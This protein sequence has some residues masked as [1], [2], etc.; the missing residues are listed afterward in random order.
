M[1]TRI[2]GSRGN[3]Q[4]FL[5]QF[6]TAVTRRSSHLND[7]SEILPGH[8][9]YTILSH[10]NLWIVSIEV[11]MVLQLEP[12]HRMALRVEICPTLLLL[13]TFMLYVLYA[14][15]SVYLCFLS[16]EVIP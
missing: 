3:V 4:S 10:S 11:G 2:T 5:P 14:H 15:C 16:D 9:D 8:L 7:L 6:V 1:E 12:R 13:M